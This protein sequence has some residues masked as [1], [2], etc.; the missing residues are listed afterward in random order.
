MH[1]H[2]YIES[3]EL[4]A[5]LHWQRGAALNFELGEDARIRVSGD[6]DP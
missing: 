3:G 2:R 5:G 1:S 4:H 6:L